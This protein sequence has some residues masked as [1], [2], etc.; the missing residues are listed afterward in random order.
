[1]YTV[2]R[3][4]KGANSITFYTSGGVVTV[5]KLQEG[6]SVGVYTEL[7]VTQDINFQ[8]VAGGIE[9]KHIFPWGTQAGSP[10]SYDLGTSDARFNTLWLKILDVLNAVRFRSTLQVDGAASMASINTGGLGNFLIGQNLRTTDSPTFSTVNATNVVTTNGP[11]K[12]VDNNDASMPSVNIGGF[13][14]ATASSSSTNPSITIGS[15]GT[16]VYVQKNSKA[17]SSSIYIGRVSGGTVLQGQYKGDGE[18]SSFINV[19]AWR[20]A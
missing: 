19:I 20:I 10:G 7:A 13:S 6:T 11:N 16:W 12:P 4:T 15:G 17:S 14:Y 9:V 18:D 8:L 5:Y 2:T 1:L 3:L